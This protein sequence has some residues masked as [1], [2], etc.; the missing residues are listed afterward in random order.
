MICSTCGEDYDK[1][2]CE[3]RCVREAT[4]R[5]DAEDLQRR[6]QELEETVA[7]LAESLA[8]VRGFLVL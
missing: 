5:E 2:N 6:V 4:A 1:H 8:E 3:C 7:Q